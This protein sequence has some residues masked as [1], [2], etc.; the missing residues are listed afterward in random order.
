MRLDLVVLDDMDR[1]VS[2]SGAVIRIDDQHREGVRSCISRVRLVPELSTLCWF[3]IADVA[4]VFLRESGIVFSGL[5][6]EM[7]VLGLLGDAN[8]WLS[9]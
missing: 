6:F 7:A 5:N 1:V 4:R 3:L 9:H 2:R 8:R